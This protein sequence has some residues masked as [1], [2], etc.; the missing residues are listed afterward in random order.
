[1][2]IPDD[3]S[4]QSA[5]HLTVTEISGQNLTAGFN[6]TASFTVLNNYYGY[7]AI[8]DVDVSVSAASSSFPLALY[9]DNHY[10]YDSIPLGQSVTINL[11]IY[12]PVSAIGSTYYGTVTIMYR[13]LGDISYT[14]ETHSLSFAVYGWIHLVLYGIVLTPS[15]TT[16]GG[17]LTVSGNILNSGNLAAYNANVSVASN[18]MLPESS[19]SVFIGEIDPN[20][21]R[22]FSLQAFFRQN[23]QDGNYSLTVTVSA[24]DQGR[25]GSPYTAN[26]EAKVQIRR[27][28]TQRQ[29]RTTGTGL[30]AEILNFLRSLY[31]T[32]FGS[33]F[34]IGTLV[35]TGSYLNSVS[36]LN[37][38]SR[39]TR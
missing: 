19:S 14:Q 29:Q 39:R 38:S 4:A 24:V 30:V 6:N 27:A 32:F 3:I 28:T 10:H 2:L 13:A 5:T 9:G 35:S 1:M 15:V 11:T 21:P 31:A 34:A 18:I 17:N 8:Y 37:R 36:V 33:A 12:A 23:L 7:S 25:P 26:Q 22:P 16:A 20:I